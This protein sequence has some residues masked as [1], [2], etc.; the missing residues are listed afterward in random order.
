MKF[1][2]VSQNAKTLRP[3]IS[4]AAMLAIF[5]PIGV[6]SLW[7]HHQF[8]NRPTKWIPYT[9][10]S[11]AEARDSGNV[12]VV[13]IC[14]DWDPITRTHQHA[15]ED[16]ELKRLA[17]AHGVRLLEADISVGSSEAQE[18]FEESCS[19]YAAPCLLIY[20]VGENTPIET[21]ERVSVAQVI[22]LLKENLESSR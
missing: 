8:E 12:T 7:I 22:E 2:G 13:S 1:V 10:Q 5:I 11:F 17:R 14:A 3:R 4:L 18:F 19:H 16:A 20:P 9:H 15:F 6:M 21:Y